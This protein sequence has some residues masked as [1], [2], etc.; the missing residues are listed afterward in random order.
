M[1]YFAIPFAVNAHSLCRFRLGLAFV[2][3]QIDRAL[4]QSHLSVSGLLDQAGW[5]MPTDDQPNIAARTRETID[6]TGLELS[7]RS[8][9]T[10][11][12]GCLACAD[13]TSAVASDA[14]FLRLAI[15]SISVL[16]GPSSQRPVKWALL[17]LATCFTATRTNTA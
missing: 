8:Q 11:S 9:S 3:H 2:Q 14:S 10:T 16:I 5:H 15:R 6:S 4:A 1:N 13:T 17:R 7:T 12:V